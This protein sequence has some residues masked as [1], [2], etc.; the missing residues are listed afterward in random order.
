MDIVREHP[1]PLPVFSR[2]VIETWC[3][4]FLAAG[5]AAEVKPV[6]PEALAASR[7]AAL[8]ARASAAPRVAV[9]IAAVR[10]ARGG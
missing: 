9:V 1:E 8:L 5:I 10:L 4:G 6:D 3:M 2:H 7:R